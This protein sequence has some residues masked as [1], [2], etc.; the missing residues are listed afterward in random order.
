MTTRYTLPGVDNR[1]RETWNHIKPYEAPPQPIETSTDSKTMVPVEDAPHP[2]TIA[3]AVPVRVVEFAREP[4]RYR[5]VRFYQQ[6]IEPAKSLALGSNRARQRMSFVNMDAALNVYIGHEA[7]V[8]SRTGYPL[9]PTDPPMETNTQRPLWLY[10]ADTAQSIVV[11]IM[12]E[13]V[14]ELA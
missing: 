1:T 4:D 3:D 5:D 11:G 14:T 8:N 7:T 2:T 10:N 6:T 9:R 13:F 12:E